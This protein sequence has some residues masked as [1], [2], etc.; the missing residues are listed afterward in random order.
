M[1]FV[2][3]LGG[4]RAGKSRLAQELAVRS[5]AAVTLVATAEAGD[6]EMADRISRHRA[7]R[8]SSWSTIE[9]PFELRRAVR[10]VPEGNLVVIDCLT[11]WVSNLLGRDEGDQEIIAAAQEVAQTLVQ[12]PRSGVVVSNEVGL[13]IVPASPLGRRFRDTLGSVNSVF[14][15]FAEQTVLVVA[16]RVHA[17]T[18]AAEFIKGFPLEAPPE[19]R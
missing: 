5:G 8:P 1:A 11:L 14:A 18:P 2:L 13:G 9:E 10:A 6:E 3:L 19:H 7:Q 15:A 12:R 4:A 17:L 16:G